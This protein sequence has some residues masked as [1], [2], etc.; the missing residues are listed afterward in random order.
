MSTIVLSLLLLLLVAIGLAMRSQLEGFT[1]GSGRLVPVRPS[2]ASLIATPQVKPVPQ[3]D[4]L[5]REQEVVAARE[6]GFKK[7]EE[8]ERKPPKCPKCPR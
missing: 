7:A 2:L 6:A 4:T 5:A 8:E 1:S 3:V